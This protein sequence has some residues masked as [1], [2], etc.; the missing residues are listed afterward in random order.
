M[1][2]YMLKEELGHGL[3]CDILLASC[4]NGHFRELIN[5]HK[6]VVIVM[7]CG[8]YVGHVIHSDGLPGLVKC[9]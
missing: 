9:R 8:W 3:N 7:L 5:N 4:Q 1:N 6:N 2:P